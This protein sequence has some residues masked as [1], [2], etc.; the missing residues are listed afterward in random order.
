MLSIFIIIIN[1]IHLVFLFS[2][3]AIYF[4]TPKYV[5]YLFKYLFLLILLIPIHWDLFDDKCSLTLITES[6]GGLKNTTFNSQFSEKYLRW[7]YEPI[8]QLFGREWNTNNLD[9]IIVLHW[10]LNL[11]LMWYYCFY[12]YIKKQK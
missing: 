7:L 12:I 8:L 6:I 11:I 5:N 1:I 2:P 10:V 3:I 4:I 9:L